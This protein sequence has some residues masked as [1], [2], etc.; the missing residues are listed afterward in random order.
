MV[1]LVVLLNEVADVDLLLPE[2][3]PESRPGRSGCRPALLG[4]CS[5]HRRLLQP[6]QPSRV[7]GDDE[8]FVRGDDPRRHATAR[9]GD[10]WPASGVCLLVEIDTEPRRRMADSCANLRGVLPD[11]GREHEPVDTA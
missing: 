10:P 5:S 8:F 11:A 6:E 1:R 2:T 4:Y 3:C 9:A 7:P